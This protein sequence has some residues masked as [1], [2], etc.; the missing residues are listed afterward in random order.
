[1]HL[2]GFWIGLYKQV[3]AQVQ[4]ELA[5]I[6]EDTCHRNRP[7][8]SPAML[9]EL[10]LPGYRIL[11]GSFLDHGIEV[12]LV[13]TDG[14]RRPLIPLSVE[15]GATGLCPMQ[16][17]AGGMDVVE[18]EPPLPDDPLLKLENI[19]PTLHSA[20]LSYEVLDAMCR[21]GCEKAID[22]LNGRHPGSVVNSGGRP[23]WQQERG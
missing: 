15:G 23:W 11:T 4:P 2:A 19:V 14:V 6:W 13:H 3:L 16:V 7:L 21:A 18:P 12:I 22:L 20:A 9:E 10:L 17:T 5:L 1:M 8:I